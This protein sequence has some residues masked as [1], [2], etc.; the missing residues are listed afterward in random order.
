MNT[1]SKSHRR[2]HANIERALSLFD[3]ASE[4]ADHIAFLARLLK[5][6]ATGQPDN[7]KDLP[8]KASITACLARCLQPHLPAGVHQKALEVYREILQVIGTT[9]LARDLALYLPPLSHPLAFANLSTRPMVLDLYERYIVQLPVPSLRPALKAL[10][11]SLLPVIEEET[12]EDFEKSLAIFDELRV[13][14]QKDHL[15]SYF[16]QSL[17]AASVTSPHRR[18]GVL[19]YLTR[20][21]PR[22][23][24]QKSSREAGDATE[25]VIAVIKPEPGLLVRCFATG[26]QDDQGLVQRGFLD[27]LVSR[28]PLG[29]IVLQ[30][31]AHEGDL[32]VLVDAAVRIVLRKDMGLNRRLWTWLT[33][34][35]SKSAH[36][37]VT[38]PAERSNIRL[39]LETAYFERC[40]AQSFI[41]VVKRMLDNERVDQASRVLPFRVL[42][43]FMDKWEIA[44]V[45]VKDVFEPS[46]TYLH[47]Y[48]AVATSQ[49]AFDEVFKSALSFFEGI[50]SV[51]MLESMQDMLANEHLHLLAFVV[52]NFNLSTASSTQSQLLQF[53]T[54]VARQITH[55]QVQSTM[56]TSALDTM[57][58]NITHPPVK[59]STWDQEELLNL[60]KSVS[61]SMN[62]VEDTESL[63]WLCSTFERVVAALPSQDK[64]VIQ[65]LFQASIAVLVGQCQILGTS[66]YPRV[67]LCARLVIAILT[68]HRERDIEI[69][70]SQSNMVDATV[71]QL[72]QFLAPSTPQSHISTVELI[73]RLHDLAEEGTVES[74]FLLIL[75]DASHRDNAGIKAYI[76]CWT[77]FYQHSRTLKRSQ[78]DHMPDLLVLI[79]LR[80][81]DSSDVSTAGD[82]PAQWLSTINSITPI[83]KA[84]LDSESDEA[85]NIALTVSRIRK[86][87]IIV[88][89]SGTLQRAFSKST[90]LNLCH[91][92]CM[93][94]LSSVSTS[95]PIKRECLHILVSLYSEQSGITAPE[96][97]VAFLVSKL[98]SFDQQDNMDE[99]IVDA[100]LNVLNDK[101]VLPSSFIGILMR[102][103]DDM[104][105]DDRLEKWVTLLCNFLPH[106]VSLLP[107]LLRVTNSICTRIHGL[108]EDIQNAFNGQSSRTCSEH[109]ERLIAN[110]LSGLEYILARAHQL[111]HQKTSDVPSSASKEVSSRALANDRLTVTLCMQDAIRICAEL[112]SWQM[113]SRSS[114]VMSPTTDTRSFQFAAIRLR[115][116]CRRMLDKLIEAESQDCLETLMELWS[117]HKNGLVL[118]LLQTLNGARP[119]MMLPVVFSAIHHRLNT[120]TSTGL[121]QSTLTVQL[122]PRV[123][124]DFLMAYTLALEDDMLEEIWNNCTA[125]VRDILANPMPYRQVLLPLLEFEAELAKKL[126]NTNFGEDSRKAK[127]LADLTTRSFTAIYTI[128]PFH[129]DRETRDSGD[130]RVKSTQVNGSTSRRCDPTLQLLASVVPVLAPILTQFNQATA[131]FQ[132]LMTNFVGPALRSR[133]FPTTVYLEHLQLM[134]LIGSSHVVSKSW[135]KETLD[136]FTNPSLFQSEHELVEGGWLPLFNQLVSSDKGL[137]NE[138]LT[139]IPVPAAAGIMFGVGANAARIEADRKTQV[140]IRKI[141]ILMLSMDVDAVLPYLKT[142]MV[143]IEELTTATLESSPSIATR[144]EVFLLFRALVLRTSHSSLAGVWPVVDQQLRALCADI[145]AGTSSVYTTYSKLQ[146]A[147][148]LDLLLLLRPDEFQLQEW[149]FVTDTIDAI[150]PPS[151][152]QASSYA[153]E[154]APLLSLHVPHSDTMGSQPR[155]RKRPWLCVEASRRGD[156]IE[157]LLAEFFGQLSI[158]SFEDLYSLEPVDVEACR[159]DLLAD[160]FHDEEHSPT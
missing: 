40:G 132:G 14:F 81:L 121:K 49:Q 13:V 4:W 12:S 57:V 55:D 77:T 54:S 3:P 32:D 124:M 84:V 45:V 50:D 152:V 99:L 66:P 134:Q 76:D 109:V 52:T 82:P 88:R 148:L 94:T 62:V 46:M 16:W 115:G 39:E 91:T 159:Q 149:L 104:P 42:S 130:S 70:E 47:G 142:L 89:R 60:L 122:D 150:Y 107:N 78:D 128:K 67:T 98:E 37:P 113:H 68:Y 75:E 110:L 6:I 85:E 74:T 102:G 114:A 1:D 146:G 96:E 64:D 15:E 101:T 69:A 140:E 154:I 137:M 118:E 51:A 158:R 117:K 53:C 44:S 63:T 100:L 93:S 105:S 126:E 65:G 119:T 19:V 86:L 153:D 129:A 144:G 7:L 145:L 21:L 79:T 72:W 30:D 36:A 97:F 48:Q 23:P 127:E 61:R 155:K 34:V 28:L 56:L 20:Y 43:S 106:Q 35:D 5:A 131:V 108:F 157:S 33:G 116:R 147:K 71:M 2:Y 58:L 160:L 83:L 138:C 17:F 87:L 18:A 112:W 156:M 151:G 125:F 26:L 143:K 135:R 27:L 31:G 139:R 133:V 8:L 92:Y 9:G 41:R 11:L 103:L 22:L 25:T 141:V 111:V 95:L 80:L 38:S 123:C 90:D 29:A 136:A 10:I 59:L 73:W 120:A 24:D